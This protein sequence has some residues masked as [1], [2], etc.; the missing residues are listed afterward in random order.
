MEHDLVATAGRLLPDGICSVTS[1]GTGSY[2]LAVLAH[3][4]PRRCTPT[5]SSDLNAH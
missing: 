2:L 1:G 4:Y 3:G 5:S